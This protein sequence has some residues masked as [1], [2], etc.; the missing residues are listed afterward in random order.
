LQNEVFVNIG[1]KS[2]VNGDIFDQNRAYG[3]PG[4][5]FSSRFDAEMGYLNQYI[6]GRNDAFSNNPIVQMAVYTRL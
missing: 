5:R 2:A 3:A 1:D 4:Y 6:N